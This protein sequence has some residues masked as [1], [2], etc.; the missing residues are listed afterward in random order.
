MIYQVLA[1]VAFSCGSICGTAV[2]DQFCSICWTSAESIHPLL[3]AAV[4]SSITSSDPVP[5][6]HNNIMFDRW[7]A[8][9]LLLHVFPFILV[10]NNLGFFCPK[11]F[12]FF[13]AFFQN[14]ACSFRCFLV[15][16]LLVFLFFSLTSALR[17]VVN[18]LD[19]PPQRYLLIMDFR[20]LVDISL[21]LVMR[22]PVTCY[23]IQDQHLKWTQMFRLLWWNNEG[24]DIAWSWDSLSVKCPIT[25]EHLK[26]GYCVC[27][28]V[29]SW[30]C[31]FKSYCC[32]IQRQNTKICVNVQIL[33]NLLTLQASASPSLLKT[34]LISPAKTELK[35]LVITSGLMA[36]TTLSIKT[37]RL[38]QFC[39]VYVAPIY[40][41]H[42]ALSILR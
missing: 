11:F 32:G 17:L 6:A 21:D 22:V 23:Q 9:P 19:F 5:Q 35:S 24:T 28:S 12:F 15:N 31:D 16:T 14:S 30:L 10:R 29:T 39:S 26:M 1:S 25:S 42:L 13:F 2:S 4:T 40:S 37:M 8:V 3:L 41:T 36:F 20:A 18:L 38:V 33:M 34:R 7:L 27:T